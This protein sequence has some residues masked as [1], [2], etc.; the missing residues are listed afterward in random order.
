[1]LES[2]RTFTYTIIHICESIFYHYLQMYLLRM[3]LPFFPPQGIIS[4][5]PRPEIPRKKL[6][7]NFYQERGSILLCWMLYS[8]LDRLQEYNVIFF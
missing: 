1:M 4:S 2:D 8:K 6:F 3:E 7:H 5:A